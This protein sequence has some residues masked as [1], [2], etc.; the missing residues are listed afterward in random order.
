M[1]CN[2]YRRKAMSLY[3][4]IFIKNCTKSDAIRD[5]GLTIPE[6]IEYV[7]DIPYGDNLK[8][9]TLDICFPKKN[10]LAVGNGDA[11]GRRLPVIVSVHGGGYVYG[12]T[13]VYQFYC[14]SLAE[15]GFA[16]VNYNYRLAPKYKFP[17]PLEDL[18]L[19]L[20]WMAS[21]D[22]YD[23]YPVDVQNVFIVGDSAGGQIAS[24]YGAIYSNE[25][26][27]KLF[28]FKL[29]DIKLKGLGIN[30]GS[31]DFKTSVEKEGNHGFLR[32][33]IGKNPIQFGDMLDV[34]KYVTSSYPPTHIMSSKGDFMLPFAEPIYD[35]LK[36]KGVKTECKIY[37]DENIGHVF[38][39]NVKLD[40]GKQANDDQTEFFKG[41]IGE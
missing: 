3:G 20:H 25:E 8:C 34:N 5:A 16:V 39:V 35:F 17:A 4:R 41:Y 33:Y 9:Q 24:Q 19:V 7:R 29:P 22:C 32:D 26:Y 36:G 14:A 31:M 37:G 2:E 15:R 6:D 23:K 38:H 40:I 10:G 28:G 12:N 21:K 18:D 30:C 27:R 1:C 13:K 11:L